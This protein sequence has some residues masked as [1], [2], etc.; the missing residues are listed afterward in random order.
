MNEWIVGERRSRKKAMPQDG[1][2]FIVEMKKR[3]VLYTIKSKAL[4]AS[5]EIFKLYKIFKSA[6]QP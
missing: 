2:K 5:S 1:N 6:V 4:L 3:T